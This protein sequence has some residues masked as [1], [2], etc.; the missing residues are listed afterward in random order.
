MIAN[1]EQLDCHI[2]VVG[3][4][5]YIYIAL[6]GSGA[7]PRS[8]SRQLAQVGLPTNLTSPFINQEGPPREQIFHPFG[9]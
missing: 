3:V 7:I 4:Y 8:G 9:L 1:F 5:I 2:R 6:Y